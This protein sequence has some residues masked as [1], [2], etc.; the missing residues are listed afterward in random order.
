MVCLDQCTVRNINAPASSVEHTFCGKI[1][2][3]SQGSVMVPEV[4]HTR[5]KQSLSCLVLESL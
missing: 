5:W 2:C 4:K 3:N 1:G